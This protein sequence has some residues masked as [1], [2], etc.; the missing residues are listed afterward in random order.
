ML[1]QVRTTLKDIAAETGLS[2]SAVSMA[3]RNHPGFPAST[4]AKVQAAARKLRYRPDPA[5]SALVAY[6]NRKRVKYDF[7][8][9]ALLTNWDTENG[10]THFASARETIAG[11][12][13]RAREL[14]Y[15][16]QCLWSRKLASN[17]R[18]LSEVLKARGIRGVVLA[19][20][21]RS[22]ARLDLSWKDFSVVTIERPAHYPLLHHVVANHH[23]DM[24]LVWK[25]LLEAGY[26][27]P[28]LALHTEYAERSANQ[29]ESAHLLEQARHIEPANR[30]PSLLLSDASNTSDLLRG[31]IRTHRPD[32]VISRDSGVLEAAVLERVR[33]PRE[34]GYISLNVM[35]DRA[36]SS[37]LLQN[38][39]TIGA[40]AIDI[41]NSLILRNHRGENAVCQSTE[42]DS[43]W[44]PGR[45]LPM[46]R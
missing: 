46:R 1:E 11:A 34:I 25:H 41:L 40:L 3:L 12:E 6:R 18:R 28:G 31:W 43:K 2:I 36:G 10:W 38:R 21:P 22:D 7:S 27:R 42:V 26:Q 24:R 20:L 29:W 15:S 17:P 13:Q 4:L 33:V 14:G 8:V 19:P 5:L 44:Q 9:I 39:R 32:V 35:D 16:L 37:G 30:I 45:T 23:A